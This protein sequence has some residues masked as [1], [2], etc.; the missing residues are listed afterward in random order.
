[1][2]QFLDIIK[3]NQTLQINQEKD[4]ASKFDHL[5]IWLLLQLKDCPILAERDQRITTILHQ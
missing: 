5:E 4:K 2:Q 1:M 3:W